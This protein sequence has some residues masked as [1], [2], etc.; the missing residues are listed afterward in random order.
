MDIL[1]I[2]GT[3]FLGRALVEAAVAQ[4]HRV[5]LFN[6]GRSNPAAFPELET[7]IGDR[8]T[9]LEQLKGRRWDA[10]IDT[11]GYAPR[12]VEV[13][14]E[15]LKGV[16]EHYTFISTLSVYPPQGA[17]KRDEA[18]ELLPYDDEMP[19]EVSNASYGPLKVGCERVVQR[20]YPE[21]ALII[22]AGL[23]VGPHDPTNRFTYWVTRT[24]KGGDAIAPPIDQPLQFVDARDM[25]EFTL[26]Q[27]ESMTNEIYN[28]TGPERRL[29]F[30]EF[31]ACAKEALGSDV[32]FRHVSDAFLQE[33]EVGEFMELPLWVN[34]ELAESF[35]TFDC[36]R[37]LRAG[38]RFRHLETTIIDTYEWSKSAPDDITKPADLASGKEQKLLA[39]IGS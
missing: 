6:R 4:G 1:I 2:G 26:R 24:A 33:Q 11:C 19:E 25:A 29:A 3:I 37:A 17:S 14:T 34:Q 21:S 9:D 38:L 35:M 10:V 23:I 28:V 16:V 5:T 8:E 7:I 30:G 31:L 18:S 15:A 12:L 27:T 22:R 20:A 36:A 39:A 32:Q 13:S